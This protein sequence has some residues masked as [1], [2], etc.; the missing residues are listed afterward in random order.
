MLRSLR[1]WK[2]G[3]ITNKMAF[4]SKK[5]T[6][7][8]NEADIFGAVFRIVTLIITAVDNFSRLSCL[9]RPNLSKYVRISLSV[10]RKPLH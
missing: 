4:R 2:R 10:T 1:I 3:V 6:N 9:F 5:E 7:R 8:G